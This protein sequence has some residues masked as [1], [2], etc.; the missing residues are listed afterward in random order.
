VLVRQVVWHRLAA[1][2]HGSR[3]G[4]WS[5]DVGRVLER[6]LSGEE[7]EAHGWGQV[8]WGRVSNDSTGSW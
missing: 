6:C 8:G 5:S 3:W 4:R 1:N 7:W 2:R